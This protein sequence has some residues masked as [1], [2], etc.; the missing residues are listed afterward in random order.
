M[1][2][3]YEHSPDEP[4]AENDSDGMR[5]FML[6]LDEPSSTDWDALVE[7]P[8]HEGLEDIVMPH[9]AKTDKPKAR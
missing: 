9:L 1:P 6:E 4:M 7:N 8:P 3:I 2:R 5:D